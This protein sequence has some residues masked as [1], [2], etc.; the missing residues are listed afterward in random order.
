MRLFSITTVLA[1]V[2]LGGC[3]SIIN[4]ST[5]EVAFT[6]QLSQATITIDGVERGATPVSVELARGER[7]T[8]V[9]A[10]EGY[11]TEEIALEQR[12]NGWVWGNILIGGLIGLVVDASTGAM[13]RIDPETLRTRLEPAQVSANKGGLQVHIRVVSDVPPDAEKIGQLHPVGGARL[14]ASR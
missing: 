6:S 13:Y 1:A 9:M 2:V 5:Q 3:A 14:A 12:V 8:V 7:H 4:G 11:E 10:L